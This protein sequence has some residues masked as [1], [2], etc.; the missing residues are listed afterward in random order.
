MGK[1]LRDENLIRYFVVKRVKFIWNAEEDKYQKLRGLEVNNTCS[2]F[3]EA[4]GL[5]YEHQRKRRV[6]Y[7]SNSIAV[8]VTPILSLLFKEALS[9]FYVF[10]V[11]SVSVWFA[12]EY[13]YYA[14]CI[15]IISVI[16]LS[17]SIYQT[18]KMQRAL[19]NTIQTSTIVTVCRGNDVYE[20]IPSEDLV[21]GDVIEVPH[22][23][24]V[25]QCDAV[26]ISGNCIVNE[27]MLTGE[28]VPV[29]KTP[30][31]D[32]RHSSSSR[33]TVFNMKEHSKHTLFCG[34]QVIQTRYYG[35]QK[36]RAVVVRTGFLT[37]KG[38]LVRA[39][40]YPKPVD[41]KFNRDTYLFVGILASIAGIGLIYTVIVKVNS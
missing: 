36:V 19:R 18:R 32:T 20:D 33:N 5:S 12:D 40:L 28:S 29:T 7:G 4:K 35:N 10:Q 9:P 11:F 31:P 37:S 15:I 22:H 1:Q 23:G 25:M 34:T 3:H 27:S 17:T 24:C 26:L 13:Y 14:S 21:P 41:F 39:I 6:L 30:L 8:H 16:S 2:Y 38:E